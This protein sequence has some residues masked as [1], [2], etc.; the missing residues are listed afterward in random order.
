MALDALDGLPVT[1][2]GSASGAFDVARLRVPANATVLDYLP[3]DSIMV[4]LALVICHAGHGTTMAALTRGVPL[5]C[6]PGLGRDQEPIAT[7][8]SELGLGIALPR[9]A[10]T[11]MIRDAARAILADGGYRARARDFAQ[12]AGQ[13][14]GAQRAADELLRLFDEPA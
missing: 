2:L 4:T 5:V 9:D 11:R 1:V 12:L 13:P 7:R 8:V 10:S 3:H 6:V 14:D